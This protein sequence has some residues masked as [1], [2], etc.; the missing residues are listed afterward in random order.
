M[1]KI[2]F[3][4]ISYS[5]AFCS[6]IATISITIDKFSGGFLYCIWAA[7]PYLLLS[8]IIESAQSKATKITALGCSIICS[9][10]GLWHLLSVYY[11]NDAQTGLAFIFVPLWQ[12]LALLIIFLA[13]YLFDKYK[14]V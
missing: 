6:A 3:K 10:F 1:K 14:G 2:N 4:S 11:T 7:F 12:N 5:L 8:L 9:A 13:L